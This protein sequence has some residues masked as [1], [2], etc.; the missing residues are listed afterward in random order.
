MWKGRF[1]V[2]ITYTPLPQTQE[3]DATGFPDVNDLVEYQKI[4][5]GKYSS[6]NGI[7]RS[8]TVPDLGSGWGFSW[9]GRGWLM[10]AS[11]QWEILGYGTDVAGATPGIDGQ[12][13]DWMVTYFSKTL[14]TPAG[15]DIYSR[16]ADGI[17]AECIS[18]IKVQLAKMD[19]KGLKKLAG[20]IFEIPR[21]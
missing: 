15:I 5:G 13:K 4:S 14:F 12:G 2:K 9:R 16:D 3:A 11:S 6:I 1:G 8:V 21:K 19:D 18:D 17:S 7:S 10:I 20:E